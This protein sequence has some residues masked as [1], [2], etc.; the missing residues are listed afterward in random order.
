MFRTI[1]DKLNLH[2]LLLGRKPDGRYTEQHDVFFWNWQI[3]HK[4]IPKTKP[5]WPE[6]KGNIYVDAW[7]EVKMTDNFS[8][9]IVAKKNDGKP[10]FRQFVFHQSW[11]LQKKTSLKNIV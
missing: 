5:F 3:T 6:A 9:E 4:L 8:I 11:R 1:K 7:R 2:L 10:N